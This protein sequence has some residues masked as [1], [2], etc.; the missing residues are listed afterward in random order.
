M[1]LLR[2]DPG[3]PPRSLSDLQYKP[4]YKLR[5]HAATNIRI[6]F[7]KTGAAVRSANVPIADWLGA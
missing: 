6:E 7:A 1:T 2:N 3:S 5:L 4:A